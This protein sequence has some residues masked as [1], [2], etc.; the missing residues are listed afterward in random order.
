MGIASRATARV[1]AAVATGLVGALSVLSAVTPDVPWRRHLLLAVE[2]GPVIAL[3]HVLATVSGLGLVYVG[4]GI[5]RGKRRAANAAIVMLAGLAVLHAAKGL[6]YEESAVALALCALLYAARRSCNRGGSPGR[7]LVAATVAIGAV[8]LAYT[9]NVALLLASDKAHSLGTAVTDAVGALARGAWW[10]SSGRP[11]AIV[12]DVLLLVA[13]GAAIAF[14]HALLRP[15]EA[16]TGHTAA[17][18]ER[19][20]EIVARHG[21]DSL[22]P[23]ALREE[24]TF[25]FSRGGMLAYRTLRETAVVSGDP[26][27]PDGAGPRIVGDFLDFA[28]ARGWD[29]VITAA[30]GRLLDHYR[31]LGLRTVCIGEEAVVDPARFSLEGRAIRKVRQSVARAERLGWTLDVVAGLDPASVLARELSAVEARWRA[32]RDRLYGFAMCLGRLWGAPEDTSAVYALGRGPG[33]ELR[34][35]IRFARCADSLS[36][37]VMRRSGDE[38]NGLNEALIAHT[39]EWARERG[40]GEVSLNFAGF[41]HLMR[42]H[43]RPSPVQQVLK[44]TLERAHGRFQLERLMAFNNKFQPRWQRRFL[45]YQARTRLP[46]AVLRV[47]QAESYIRAPRSRVCAPRWTAPS[48]LG[49]QALPLPPQESIRLP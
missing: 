37:D 34:A 5:L 2:P 24:K 10:F 46:L 36:L 40:V 17:E 1:I 29:V 21:S 39:I 32:G 31:A 11:S 43:A 9:L 25:F 33:G 42:A 16:A 12:L 18:H 44:W 7:G 4:W 23:F 41:A 8:A 30:S 49:E 38:P 22:D 6:D 48:D 26:I 27:G 3:E 14:L 45:V 15:A 13:V 47:L 35:F 19:G 28:A 20:A